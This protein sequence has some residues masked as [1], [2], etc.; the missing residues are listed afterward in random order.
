MRGRRRRA[1]G[2]KCRGTKI[3]LFRQRGVGRCENKTRETI[4]DVPPCK[5]KESSG[6]H[7]FIQKEA[8]SQVGMLTAEGD[9]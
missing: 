8:R 4:V 3:D 9:G 5:K 7:Q 6:V 2:R 1:G